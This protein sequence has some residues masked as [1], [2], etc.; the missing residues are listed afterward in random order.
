MARGCYNLRH[1]RQRRI[2]YQYKLNHMGRYKIRSKRRH[3]HHTKRQLRGDQI[4][5]LM[6]P[7]DDQRFE[8]VS[9]E[10]KQLHHAMPLI[11]YSGRS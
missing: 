11:A 3:W 10:R 6:A 4:V 8:Y 7:R 5:E 1:H 2:P 9:L